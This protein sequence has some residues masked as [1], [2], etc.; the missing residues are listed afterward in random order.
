[1]LQMLYLKNLLLFYCGIGG[2]IDV[3]K[4]VKTYVNTRLLYKVH[5]C[6]YTTFTERQVFNLMALFLL[7]M[8]INKNAFFTNIWLPFVINRMFIYSYVVKKRL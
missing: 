4:V 5:K 8:Y 6:L 7:I 3:E 2:A 1:M